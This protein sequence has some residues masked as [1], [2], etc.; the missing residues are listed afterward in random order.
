MN[1]KTSFILKT[2]CFSIVF[3]FFAFSN[4]AQNKYSGSTIRSDLSK[5]KTTN[6]TQSSVLLLDDSKIVEEVRIIE[7]WML[8]ENFWKIQPQDSQNDIINEREWMKKHNFY[9]L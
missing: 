4:Y 3:V 2:I 8:D 5:V 1:L 7:E 9:I 6:F